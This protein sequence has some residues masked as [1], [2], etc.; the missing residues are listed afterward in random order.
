M[1]PQNLLEMRRN[2]ITAS[3]PICFPV[4]RDVNVSGTNMYIESTINMAMLAIMGER[5]MSV[6][7]A[8]CCAVLFQ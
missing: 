8:V 1:G 2:D 5:R 7:A 4:L 6:Y 3:Q